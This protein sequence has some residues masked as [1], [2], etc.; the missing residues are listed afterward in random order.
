M[1]V[2]SCQ[3]SLELPEYR[4]WWLAM[5]LST[6]VLSLRTKALSLSTKLLGEAVAPIFSF[7]SFSFWFRRMPDA[8]GSAQL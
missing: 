7:A 8:V 6:K 5:T 3:I 1:S 4:R 2:R